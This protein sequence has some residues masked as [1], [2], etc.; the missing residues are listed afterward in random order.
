M[1]YMLCYA[2]TRAVKS[3]EYIFII[4]SSIRPLFLFRRLFPSCLQLNNTEKT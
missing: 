1:K 2:E 4:L 3:S